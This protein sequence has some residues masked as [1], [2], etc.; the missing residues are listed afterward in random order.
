MHGGLGGSSVRSSDRGY[1][2][3]PP[4]PR[5]SKKMSG[6]VDP[7]E[8]S[9]V[10]SASVEGSEAEPGG[11]GACCLRGTRKSPHGGAQ[12]RDPTQDLYLSENIVFFAVFPGKRRLPEHRRP[13]G[14]LRG[15]GGR[16]HGRAGHIQPGL[17][18]LQAVALRRHR[19]KV[20]K[21]TN[22]VPMH[23]HIHIVDILGPL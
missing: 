9:V 3:R 6:G 7:S 20:G 10:G 8:V 23:L 21:R 16:A 1:Y 12:V 13:P 14:R 17:L 4:P 5:N 18:L 2:S 22:C 15:G 19:R 11:G